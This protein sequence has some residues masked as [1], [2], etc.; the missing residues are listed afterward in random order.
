[1][2]GPV[3]KAILSGC[4]KV[5]EQRI[6][7]DEGIELLPIALVSLPVYLPVY[8]AS[9]HFALRLLG[10]KAVSFGVRDFHQ[11]LL[12]DSVFSDSQFGLRRQPD[13]ARGS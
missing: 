12:F 7:V 5:A 3:P 4:L 6:V 2:S 13:W 9:S 8:I 1:M 10:Q 11:R